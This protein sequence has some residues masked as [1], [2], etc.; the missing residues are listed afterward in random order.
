MRSHPD[1]AWL[2]ALPAEAP[3]ATSEWLFDSG[4]THHIHPNDDGAIPGT[5]LPDV[6]HLRLGD[7]SKLPVYGSVEKLIRPAGL[8]GTPLRRRVLIAPGVLT[9][10]W[11][12]ASEVDVYGSTVVDS[13]TGIYI[14]LKDSRRIDASKTKS[15]LRVIKSCVERSHTTE[16]ALMT[17]S[18]GFTPPNITGIDQGKALASDCQRTHASN[19]QLSHILTLIDGS[20]NFITGVGKPALTLKPI[21]LLRLWHARLGHP[22]LPTLLATLSVFGVFHLPDTAT[23]KQ[24]SNA[25]KDIRT[26][27]F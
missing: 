15:G 1:V 23:D 6:P 2:L 12:H 17:I 21:E 14:V 18:S 26:A 25:A 10:V 11:S 22:P 3:S 8:Q 5:W 9:R 16:S 13:P 19:S 7:N 20:L 24:R 4:A 27:V